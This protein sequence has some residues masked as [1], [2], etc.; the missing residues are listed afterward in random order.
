MF[1]LGNFRN[2]NEEVRLFCYLDVHVPKVNLCDCIFFFDQKIV[3]ILLIFCI[4]IWEMVI[5]LLYLVKLLC[6]FLMGSVAV[7]KNS[8][9]VLLSM[10]FSSMA[11][12]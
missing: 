11:L 4:L 9:H 10:I 5:L 12:N 7:L 2:M 8:S 6:Y 3:V 1:Y